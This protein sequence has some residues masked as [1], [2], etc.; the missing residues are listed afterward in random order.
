MAAVMLAL[1]FVV[2]LPFIYVIVRKPILRR[3]AFRNASRRPK[4]T[5]LVILG[6]LLGT[7]I[8]TT[9][10]VVGD[11]LDSSLKSSVVQQLGPIDVMIESPG[12]AAGAEVSRLAGDAELPGAD[13]R[14]ELLRA[15]ATTAVSDRSRVEPQTII[16]E[17]DFGAAAEFGGDSAATGMSDA[18]PVDDQI[19]LGAD[20]ARILEANVGDEVTVFAFG[21]ER[22]FVV[23]DVLPRV[24][25]AGFNPNS[26]GSSA[27]TAFLPLGTM[28]DM[29]GSSPSADFQIISYYLVSG[30]GGVFDGAD[31]SQPIVEAL[32]TA[33][34]PASALVT[35]I[36][37][38]RID[39]AEEAGNQFSTLFASIGSFSIMAGA[40]LLVMIFLTLAQE[41]KQTLGMLRAVGLR[42]SS[43][44]G[45]FSLEGW[46]YAVLAG[47]VGVVVG[48]GIGRVVVVVTKSIFGGS[49][50]FSLDIGFSVEP[51]SLV[52]AF[53]AGFL[54]ALVTSLIT[55]LGIA[56]LNVIRAI[57]DLPEPPKRR[58][59]GL[60]SLG[61]VLAL[62]GALF[63]VSGL[64]TDEP[65]GILAGPAVMALGIRMVLGPSGRRRIVPTVLGGAVVAWNVFAYGAFPDAFAD[66]GINIFVTLGV[67]LTAGAVALVGANLDVLGHG[68]RRLFGPTSVTARIGLAYPLA[69]PGR[70]TGLLSLYSLV[71]FTLVFITALS[72]LFANQV[73]G[74]VDDTSG[75]FQVQLLANA[76]N[77]VAVDDLSSLDGVGRIAALQNAD[78][79]YLAP[80]IGVDE[81]TK[82]PFTYT[83]AFDPTVAEVGG[84]SFKSC[85]A[86]VPNTGTSCDNQAIWNRLSSEPGTVVVN[87]FLLQ[88][89]G[90][91]PGAG[92]KVGDTLTVR[93]TLTAKEDDLEVIGVLEAGFSFTITFVNPETF[94][95]AFGA[96]PP[97][98]FF[99]ETN[100]TS[101]EGQRD[102]ASR[103]NAEFLANGAEADPIRDV[104]E[105]FLA[106]QISFFRLIQGY[107][108]LGLVVGI[109]GLGVV[110]VRAVRERR[111]QIGM[112]RAMGFPGSSVR[113]AFTLESAFVSLLGTLIGTCLG[114]VVVWRLTQSDSFGEGFSFVVP[115]LD[116][117]VVVFG[118]LIASLIATAAPALSASRIKPAVALR[119]AD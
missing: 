25:I 35:D 95:D 97:S 38:V 102:V 82:P 79:E 106:P 5:A 89:G 93:N 74:F 83:T 99:V 70:T 71:V 14:L 18:T 109:A 100:N 43:L 34:E 66:A 53:S 67:C 92:L 45:S 113:K 2:S 58:S 29:S 49:G 10:L 108:A 46:L 88:S 107:L 42:R 3:L 114:M 23:R 98:L 104:V 80:T 36:K 62:V 91:P 69:R 33:V 77:P 24:G 9:S 59:K 61:A 17:T 57:R 48:L 32:Q 41:R 96:V 90:G 94:Q 75:G 4:E 51:S 119:L 78:A 116:L 112:L 12:I 115:W 64:A 73:D 7:A 28:A 37:R 15:V 21:E 56:R 40:V 68:L 84:P 47:L 103:I 30:P 54:I 44:V 6:A 81:F 86:G 16:M 8:I 20:T 55:S 117:A 22:S 105:E 52:I 13:G 118:A 65:N 111:R 19:V 101:I 72:S 50:D 76:A 26:Q 31:N 27:P 39:L 60:T 87:E 85:E 1:A 63:F 11:T 110:M